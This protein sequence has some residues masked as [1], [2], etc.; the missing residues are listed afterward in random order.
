MNDI[1]N[2]T[3]DI[4]CMCE[5]IRDKRLQG[6]FQ[7]A[8]NIDNRIC[9]ENE[10]FVSFPSVSPLKVGH[11][12]VFPKR[13]VTSLSKLN[14]D[15]RVDLSSF[16][17]TV[18]GRLY[19]SLGDLYYFEHGVPNDLAGGCGITH[20]HL[21]IL[22]LNKELSVLVN[23]K[24]LEEHEKSLVSNIR[25]LARVLEEQPQSSY[26]LFGEKLDCLNLVVTPVIPSQYMRKI[27]SLV[28]GNDVWDWRLATGIEFFRD[29]YFSFQPQP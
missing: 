20:A 11:M 14:E 27:I 23:T 18:C 25:N 26:L 28:L 21:H 4:C 12:L 24:V 15:E 10:Y 22:P 2:K 16:L 1:S 7:K 13:H 5:E 8:Y 6:N 17:T 29:T 3:I 19:Q 9:F